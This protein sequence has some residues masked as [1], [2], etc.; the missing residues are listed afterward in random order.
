MRTLRSKKRRLIM[1]K[2]SQG[3]MVIPV[4]SKYCKFAGKFDGLYY[5]KISI[6][7]GYCFEV[8]STKKGP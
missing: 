2:L 8:A 5:Y 4:G 6:P 1:K 3:D 7:K